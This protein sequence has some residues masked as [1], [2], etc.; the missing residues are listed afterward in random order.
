MRKS[1]ME[2]QHNPFFTSCRFAVLSQNTLTKFRQEE[3]EKKNKGE[4]SFCTTQGQFLHRTKKEY[5]YLCFTSKTKYIIWK[6]NEEKISR[7]IVQSQNIQDPT[8]TEKSSGCS[9]EPL[10][11]ECFFLSHWLKTKSTTNSYQ[12][13]FSLFCSNSWQLSS[14]KHRTFDRKECTTSKHC[15]NS[16]ESSFRIIFLLKLQEDLEKKSNRYSRRTVTPDADPRSSLFFY[17][18]S[19]LVLSQTIQSGSDKHVLPVSEGSLIHG[20]HWLEEKPKKP[21]GNK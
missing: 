14:H 1:Y 4:G 3:T 16:L 7:H 18:Y 19:S 5:T 9:A 8:S 13:R 11:S 20:C 10:N 6:K 21:G 12:K 15:R 2:E 17:R